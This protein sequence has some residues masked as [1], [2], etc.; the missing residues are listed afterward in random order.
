MKFLGFANPDSFYELG[1]PKL[2]NSVNELRE[3]SLASENF[4]VITTTFAPF[5]T[6]RCCEQIKVNLSYMK[7]KVVMI[8]LASGLVQ[9]PL[10]YTHCSIEDLSIIISLFKN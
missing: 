6:L 3:I 2:P 5:Q 7:Q 9:G 10:G 1:L 4:D 8:G